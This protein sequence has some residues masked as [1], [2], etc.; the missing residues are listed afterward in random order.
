MSQSDK[1]FVLAIDH[2]TSGVKTSMVSTDGLVIDSEFEK[3][4][5]YFLDHG[6]AEQDP[7]ECVEMFW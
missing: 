6:G 1:K 2:G 4:P 5:I 3:T 7:E